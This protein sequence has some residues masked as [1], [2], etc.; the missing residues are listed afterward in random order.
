LTVIHERGLSQTLKDILAGLPI[1][2]PI[3]APLLGSLL[4]A[5]GLSD[6]DVASASKTS[7]NAEQV[8]TLASFEFA[9]SN[10]VH[11]VLLSDSN[12][13]G[14][15]QSKL[16]VRGDF[17]L[18]ELA[19]AVPVIGPFLQP[20]VS[21]LKALNLYSVDAKP[22]SVFSLALLNEDQS[23]KLVQF[24]T[25]LRQEVA[26]ILPNAFNSTVPDAS[27]PSEADPD[28]AKP[29]QSPDTPEGE[30]SDDDTSSPEDSLPAQVPDSTSTSSP[31]P[32]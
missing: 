16:K 22:G 32:K 14:G 12:L 25:I 8:A 13:G 1:L 15:A 9:L 26:N 31:A 6:M 17:P 7:L 29:P 2:G 11:K 18:G 24:Q 5:I 3:L 21:L 27:S 30:G 10:A 23:A 28:G 19:T 4:G 20:F